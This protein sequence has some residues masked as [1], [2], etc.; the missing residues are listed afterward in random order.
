MA[1][2]ARFNTSVN[3]PALRRS[4]HTGGST[5]EGYGNTLIFEARV[6]NVDLVSFTAD[7][8]SKFDGHRYNN[9]PWSSPYQHF[10]RGQGFFYIPEP[11]SKCHVCCPADSTTPYIL[12]FVVPSESPQEDELDGSDART[13]FRGGKPTGKFGDMG[14]RG[15]DGNFVIL[16]RGGTLQI[17]CGALAQRIYLPL[18]NMIQD[19]C[20]NWGVATTGSTWQLLSRDPRREGDAAPTQGVFTYRLDSGDAGAFLRV[21]FGTFGDPVLDQLEEAGP[22]PGINK[23]KV[24]D[25]VVEVV[26]SPLGFSDKGSTNPETIKNL[27][28]RFLLDK[29]GNLV[30]R[31]KRNVYIRT[32][33]SF[34]VQSDQD[35]I[36]TAKRSLTLTSNAI[37]RIGGKSTTEVTGELVKLGPG[38]AQVA[39][40]GST[41]QCTITTPIPIVTSVGPGTITPG[42]VISGLVM[43]GKPNVL[44]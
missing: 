20:Q 31:A 21:K 17:G 18:Q 4:L 15:V 34:E 25:P 24:G 36:L 14:M 38:N 33:G 44:V 5:P 29:T 8:L 40:V 35:I 26:L 23:Y 2:V 41:V 27:C 42:A 6:L 19:I 39:H 43:T 32:N 7:V 11:G 16:H 30:L 10:T 28:L 1:G 37:A 3:N 9:I 13:S 12:D 22:G